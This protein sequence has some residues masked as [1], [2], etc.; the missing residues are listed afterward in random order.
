MCVFVETHLK[1]NEP[2]KESRNFVAVYKIRKKNGGDG[3]TFLAKKPCKLKALDLCAENED[4][5]CVEIQP[6]G[7]IQK[8]KIIAVYILPANSSTR[9]GSK[10][11]FELIVSALSKVV[12]NELALICGDLNARI[13]GSTPMMESEA[14]SDLCGK[15]DYVKLENVDNSHLRATG[16]GAELIDF[17]FSHALT[18]LD[19]LQSFGKNFPSRFTCTQY[20]G[21]S[22]TDYIL[23]PQKEVGLYNRF[24]MS[25]TAVF[26]DHH[27][28][29]WCVSLHC[30]PEARFRY[31]TVQNREP[32]SVD[33]GRLCRESLNG[34]SLLACEISGVF[35]L[36]LVEN[37]AA[38]T[39]ERL[40]NATSRAT[41]E[42]S[43][44]DEKELRT[45]KVQRGKA[46]E[47]VNIEQ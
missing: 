16:R 5:L 11:C 23:V 9:P 36:Q 26:A 38:D 39:K 12:N 33:L 41:A 18:P 6:Y 35:A 27:E 43:Y 14:E 34:V 44:E 19:A 7:S 22:V 45:L 30:Q 32:I 13:Y 42:Y 20:D 31:G 3:I 47:N 21:S 37:I 15:V 46:W 1:E 24:K 4:L 17:C 40:R 10:A 8:L 28:L 29:S 25:N 2:A